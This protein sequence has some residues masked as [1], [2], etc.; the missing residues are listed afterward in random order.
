MNNEG[1]TTLKNK[2]VTSF[3][4]LFL[5]ESFLTFFLILF[6]KVLLTLN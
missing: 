4:F 1:A 6:F 2:Y 5:I 3:I